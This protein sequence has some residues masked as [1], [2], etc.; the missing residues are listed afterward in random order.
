MLDR[1]T[2]NKLIDHAPLAITVM[3]VVVFLAAAAG[4]L[5]VGEPPLAV[6]SSGWRIA[7]AL[8]GAGLTAAG[9]LL[10]LA[11]SDA[12]YANRDVIGNSDR[13][14]IHIDSPRPM[15]QIA[16]ANV[17]VIG[18]Y[19]VRP[20]AG[21]LRLFTMT[22][23][24]AKLVQPQA[25]VEAFDEERKVWSGT[26]HL[27]D[28]PRYSAFIVAALAGASGA[29][30]W[31]YHDKVAGTGTDIPLDGPLPPDIVACQRIWV[32]RV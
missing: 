17:V 11:G 16:T 29:A 13:Y 31:D 24:D 3:G 23:P 20:P 15:E 22:T 12:R 5:P 19:A 4:G 9:V 27:P 6:A 30:L 18:S 1:S 28:P 14:G 32:E 7:L 10:L 25:V 2:L 8:L 26:I 21:A